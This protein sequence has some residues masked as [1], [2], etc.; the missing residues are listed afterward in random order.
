M[1][2]V[3]M[4]PL[5]AVVVICIHYAAIALSIISL[6]PYLILLSIVAS[7]SLRGVIPSG[8]VAWKNNEIGGLEF[9]LT[10]TLDW[11]HALLYSAL[12]LL[13]ALKYLVTE[14]NAK[15]EINA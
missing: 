5:W 3:F 10:E 8:H 12:S 1:L 15:N 4:A 11:K 14:R 9:S 7:L 13:V 6:R 2:M